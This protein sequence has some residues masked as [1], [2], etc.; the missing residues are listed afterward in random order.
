MVESLWHRTGLIELTKYASIAL[1]R[2]LILPGISPLLQTV[3]ELF[4]STSLNVRGWS[5]CNKAGFKKLQK[6]IATPPSMRREADDES[7]TT[8]SAFGN[9]RR[10][11]SDMTRT[12]SIVVRH[13][14]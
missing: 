14:V 11:A 9:L 4:Q 6:S 3:I 13:E 7:D 10:Y 1:R 2:P 8:E 5:A 12:G